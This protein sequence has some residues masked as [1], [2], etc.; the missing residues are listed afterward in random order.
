MERDTTIPS[1]LNPIA[2]SARRPKPSEGSQVRKIVFWGV[3]G[4]IAVL[5]F[6]Y[7]GH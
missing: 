4:L 1:I 2:E 7:L 5:A 3:L 6:R